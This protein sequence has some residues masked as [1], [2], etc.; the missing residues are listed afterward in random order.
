MASTAPLNARPGW[1]PPPMTYT[2]VPSATT[3]RPWRGVGSGG[4]EIHRSLAVSN[5]SAS[6]KVPPSSSP[7]TATTSPVGVAVAAIPP[8]GV[9]MP[10]NGRHA[11]EL[12]SYASRS[13]KPV[14]LPARPPTA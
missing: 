8:R 11:S 12:G 4:S 14:R 5:A 10:G 13:S 3:P 6:S 1:G 7:P 9:G 2:V